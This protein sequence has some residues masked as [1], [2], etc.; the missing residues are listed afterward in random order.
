MAAINGIGTR[1]LGATKRDE[2][3][4]CMAYWFFTFLWIPIAPVK[5]IRF[6]RTAQND[7]HIVV[8][9]K[10]PMVVSEV[11]L[12]YFRFLVIYPI[13]IFWPMPLAVTEV[14]ND[15]LKWPEDYYNY[16]IA[17]AIIWLV[18]VTWVLLAR[19]NRMGLPKNINE[20]LKRN[21][22]DLVDQA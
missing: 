18:V 6:E 15:L 5:K 17:F 20:I 7:W 4:E 10:E 2:K 9:G 22:D 14:Y 21:E 11:L 13:V 8:L 19:Y 12:I 16:M 1:L 3:G